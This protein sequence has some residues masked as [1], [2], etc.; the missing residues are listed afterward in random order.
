M[1]TDEYVAIIRRQWIKHF[2]DC[3]T[4]EEMDRAATL[5]GT[6]DGSTLRR[7][8]REL[9][10]ISRGDYR[11]RGRSQMPTGYEPRTRIGLDT[12]QTSRSS[13]H[14]CQGE[15]VHSN[16]M[17]I[18]GISSPPSYRGDVGRPPPPRFSQ[19][20]HIHSNI[21]TTP[22][23]SSPPSY[24]GDVGRP[25]PP[26]FSQ[27]EHVHSNVM[28]TPG[29]SSPPSYRGD[30][31][32]PPPPRFSQGE[33]IHSNVMTTPGISSPPSY[34]GD[35]GRPPSSALFSRS[36]AA[37]IS[38]TSLQRDAQ[39]DDKPGRNRPDTMNMFL[40][41]EGISW[42]ILKHHQEK[43]TF[44]QWISIRRDVHVRN[45]SW[46]SFV[47]HESTDNTLEWQTGISHRSSRAIPFDLCKQ[48]F[49]AQRK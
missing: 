10:E 49:R 8:E 6:N 1:S 45:W 32:R 24:R 16:V 38:H 30:V 47:A 12:P 37:E 44:G 23:I 25:P 48:A 36:S 2:L 9:E 17:T 34:R 43:K 19:G 13:P 46:D 14:F 33:H 15:H 11:S 39:F 27:G 28:T 31:G 35:V 26:H 42:D 22:G 21:M 18:P 7:A 4:K 20:E 40:P 41:G 29:I 5:Q 3:E